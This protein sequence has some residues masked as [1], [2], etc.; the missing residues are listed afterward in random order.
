MI[1]FTEF[2]KAKTV[3]HDHNINT[4]IVL[5]SLDTMADNVIYKSLSEKY[6]DLDNKFAKEVGSRVNKVGDF[7]KVKVDTGHTIYFGLIR[8]ID[9]FQPYILDTTRVINKIMDNVDKDISINNVLFPMPSTDEIKLSDSIFIP[10]ICE[11][12]LN[13]KSNVFILSNGDHNKYIESINN[14][15]ITYKKDSWKQ[16]WMLTLDDIILVFIIQELITINHDF[17]INK[18]NLVKCYKK[19]YD[20]GMFKKIEWYETQ[21]GPFFKL[22]LPKSNSL[23]NHGLILNTHHYSN[24]EPKKFACVLGPFF[25][26]LYSLTNDI[27][28]SNREKISKIAQEIRLDLIKA[29]QKNE[30]ESNLSSD[31]TKLFL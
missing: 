21:Y 8:N 28:Y 22:F 16:D 23:V 20:N 25:P 11:C 24:I 29:N 7:I 4:I 9:K 17:R 5:L 18:A 10:A 1:Q 12:F 19:C 6:Q 30:N 14:N 27:Y 13:R 3:Y 31:Q 15:I 2:N 26:L